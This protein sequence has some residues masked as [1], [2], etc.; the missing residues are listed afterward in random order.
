MTLDQARA[1]ALY[2]TLK[3]VVRE[4]TI[5]TSDGGHAH[6]RRYLVTLES[7]GAAVWQLEAR[8]GAWWIVEG[9]PIAFCRSQGAADELAKRLTTGA[10]VMTR[11][12]LVSDDKLA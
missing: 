8:D 12:S 6:P 9:E 3:N 2:G 5:H 10:V 4:G 11:S 1:T 7:N